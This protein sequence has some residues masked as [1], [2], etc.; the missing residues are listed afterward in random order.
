MI[1]IKNLSKS[2]GSNQVLNDLNFSFQQGKVYGIVGEN[3][4]GKT[5]FFNCIAGYERFKG[6]VEFSNQS[7]QKAIGYLPTNPEFISYVTG[8]EYLKLAALSRGLKE[9]DVR[10][11]NGF[12]LP[13]SEYVANYSTGM[14]KKIAL[15]AILLQQNEVFILD[16]PFNGVDIQ[17]NMAIVELIKLLKNQGKLVFIASHIFSTLNEVCS[18]IVHLKDG[19]FNKVY[20]P[21]EFHELEQKMKQFAVAPILNQFGF[22]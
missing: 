16:E 14:K 10:S 19:S 20:Q 22:K 8:F 13:L 9:V 12:D 2:Y 4:A 3:G 18:E 17:S 11:K 7:H 1:T 15:T 21:A 5:T 6:S